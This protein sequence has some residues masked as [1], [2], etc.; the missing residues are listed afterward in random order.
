[1]SFF[2]AVGVSQS[3][4]CQTI[5]CGLS[6]SS[7]YPGT[8]QSGLQQHLMGLSAQGGVDASQLAQAS[9]FLR[10]LSTKE[11]EK[12]MFGTV[13]ADVKSFLVEHRGTIYFLVAALLVDHF[14][15]KGVFK[16]RLQNM[17]ESLVKKVEDK[18]AS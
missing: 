3:T 4:H 5:T 14:L 7:F 16:V 18:V 10:A 11:K 9:Q 1:M 13:V 15:F 8:T 17:M 12:T 6:N 2:N